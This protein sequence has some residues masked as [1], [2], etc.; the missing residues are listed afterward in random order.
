[1][2]GPAPKPPLQPE[3]RRDENDTSCVAE[4]LY[5]LLRDV[6]RVLEEDRANAVQRHTE[7]LS[8]LPEQ[9]NG[10]LSAGQS[11]WPKCDSTSRVNRNHQVAEAT[12]V[13]PSKSS[14]REME[15]SGQTAQTGRVNRNHQVAEAI[16]EAM[17][18]LPPKSSHHEVES[19]GGV[20]SVVTS[21]G[22]S[23]GG[24]TSGGL[25]SGGLTS[26]GTISGSH[27]CR[28]QASH[29]LRSLAK[30]ARSRTAALALD[31]VM[32]PTG[33]NTTEINTRRSIEF[34]DKGIVGSLE[35]SV[36]GSE[37]CLSS[38]SDIVQHNNFEHAFAVVIMMNALVMSFDVQYRGLQ[39]GF[40]MG[41]RGMTKRADE[42]W[43]GAELAFEILDWIFGV[44]LTLEVLLRMLGFRC[45]Y[46][47]DVWNYLDLICLFAFLINKVAS[48]AIPIDRQTIQLLRL[49]RLLR[50]IRLIRTLEGLDALYLLTTAIRGMNWILAWTVLLLTVLLVTCALLLT[51]IL[52]TFYF[53]RTPA[54]DIPPEMFE[55]FGTWT[56]CM[57]S[58]FE[59]TLANWPPVARLLCEEVSEW[60]MLLCLIHKLTIGLAVVGVM[61]GV[62]LQETF[63]VA[64][65]DDLIMVR[66]K[67][68]AAFVF[69]TKMKRL[70]AALDSDN[71]G[72]LD[73][74]EFVVI[75]GHP[76]VR[77]WLAS[78]DIETDDLR[79]L[80]TL[81]DLNHTGRI[82]VDDFLQQIPRMRGPVRTFDLLA[83]QH[84]I[85]DSYN[86]ASRAVADMGHRVQRIASNK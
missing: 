63:K 24:V 55:Y 45:M 9:V 68:R 76:E 65:T 3:A 15:N 18:V 49:F 42:H 79:S 83:L 75:A 12:A 62:M 48:I 7:I 4:P 69:Q 31:S 16:A 41:Y 29:G 72:F 73:Y 58:M 20:K 28:V 33:T 86:L 44:L 6:L 78:M 53:E 30:N 60:F 14:T 25:T 46:I 11:F 71:D 5:R 61:N 2:L 34:G 19:S 22:P 74:D 38:V 32:L 57:A 43:P 39:V 13:L 66:Q 81:I 10:C 40:D 84:S 64:S 77:H 67:K 52:H 8:R 47:R 80:F 23:S 82:S 17:A 21:G 85:K 54:A 36:S 59:L 27:A 37:R 51:Q 56:R 26:K 1:M 50:L 70:F 35:R